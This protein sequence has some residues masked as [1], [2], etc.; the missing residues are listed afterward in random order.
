M[1]LLKNCNTDVKE[2][3]VLIKE[4]TLST[5]LLYLFVIVVSFLLQLFLF[6]HKY[7]IKCKNLFQG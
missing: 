2:K 1:F 4:F 3:Q 5:I 6:D 7:T